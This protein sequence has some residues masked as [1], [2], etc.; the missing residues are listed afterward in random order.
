MRC[1]Q[2]AGSARL[3]F[4]DLAAALLFAL[5]APAIGLVAQ[6]THV[7]G[8]G[9]F[10]EIRDALAIATAGD[11][12]LVHPGVYA[13]F[14]AL[15]PVTIRAAAPGTVD[16]RY[17]QGFPAF[18][19]THF[20]PPTGTWS[21]VFGLRFI[22]NTV[23]AFPSGTIAH[24]VVVDRGGVTFDSCTFDARSRATLTVND[25]STFLQQ[26]TVSN[27]TTLAI[28]PIGP[29]IAATDAT[30][31]LIDTAVHG[32]GDTLYAGSPAID[33]TNSSLH[34]SHVQLFGMQSISQPSQPAV[35][36]TG[37]ALWLCDSTLTPG[38]S[39]CALETSGTATHLDRCTIQST[40]TNCSNPTG[41]GLLGV[42]RPQPPQH[43]APFRLDFTTA[44]NGFVAVFAN[45]ALAAQQLPHLV[46]PALID[47]PSALP[48]GFLIADNA[49][50]AAGS[51]MIP[52]GWNYVG[53][54][55]WFQGLTGTTLPLQTSPL[56]GGLVR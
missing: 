18:E 8:P 19:A 53:I 44:P 26:C 37:G 25:A 49:G 30:L 32:G 23:F 36:A 9:G 33:A 31:S 27:S 2:P 5:G 7:V 14:E 12:I 50:L 34:G 40:G 15:V 35:R 52:F 45:F 39:A 6:T 24:H 28:F 46:Q 22:G 10:T 13:H 48:A 3:P 16:V 55:L 38:T 4:T 20:A 54:G 29:G 51:W 47:S 1:P 41:T 11:H 43:G 21:H 56:A 17:D 42:T